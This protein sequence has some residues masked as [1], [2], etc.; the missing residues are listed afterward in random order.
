MLTLFDRQK[1]VAT[2]NNSDCTY[3]GHEEACGNKMHADSLTF[4]GHCW[5][6]SLS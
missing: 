3:S 6:H 4:V 2:P 1:G 5:H